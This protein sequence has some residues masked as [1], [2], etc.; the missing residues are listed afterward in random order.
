M[1]TWKGRDFEDRFTGHDWVAVEIQLEDGH[2]VRVLWDRREVVAFLE[3][4]QP[5]AKRHG[6]SGYVECSS[7]I[8]KVERFDLG[9]KDQVA[10]DTDRRV[11]LILFKANSGKPPCE[12]LNDLCAGRGPIDIRYREKLG[13]L[14]DLT[15][16]ADSFVA[17]KNATA[18]MNY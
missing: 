6:F 12:V 9:I 1:P 16:P 10:L 7:A 4:V 17:A 3:V 18:A 2:E 15:V 13:E 11:R 5:N 14:I 8:R